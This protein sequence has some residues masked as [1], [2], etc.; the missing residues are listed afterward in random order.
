MA[1][2]PRSS[3]TTLIAAL[4]VLAR[5]IQSEDGVAN[6]A[7]A[8]AAHRLYELQCMLRAA[9]PLVQAEH[10]AQHVWCGG[11]FTPN[12]IFPIDSLY[13]QMKAGME[14]C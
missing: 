5:D 1:T 14:A 11:G 3:T 2:L 4:E 9:W 13:A 6:A 12:R 7:I 8:E 10:R